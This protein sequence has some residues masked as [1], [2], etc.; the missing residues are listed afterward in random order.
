[1]TPYRLSAERRARLREQRE[2]LKAK[3]SDFFAEVSS[4][5]FK[6]DPVGISFSDNTDEYDPEAG[7]VIPRIGLC[8]TAAELTDVLHE[9]FCRWFDAETV[10]PRSHYEALAQAIWSLADTSLHGGHMHTPVTPFAASAAVDIDRLYGLDPVLDTHT[11]PRCSPLTQFARVICPYC[12]SGY[13]SAVDLTAGTQDT[14]EDCQLC[15]RSIELAIVV[16]D[17]AL[18]QVIARRLDEA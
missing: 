8:K 3:Y 6:H 14:I 5:M 10:G 16:I 7:T 2:V 17:G 11:D 12:G 4:L 15:C 9:E 18:K 13:D 1:M